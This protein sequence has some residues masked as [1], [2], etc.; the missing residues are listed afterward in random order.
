MTIKI[1]AVRGTYRSITGA[2]VG[3]IVMFLSTDK[4][5]QD[6]PKKVKVNHPYVIVSVDELGWTRFMKDNKRTCISGCEPNQVGR[7]VII[8]RYIH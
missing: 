3:D 5:N 6:L 2:D 7:Y 4:K 8:S 1:S